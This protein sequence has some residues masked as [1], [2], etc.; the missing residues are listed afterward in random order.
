ML[1]KKIGRFIS[2]VY[3]EID[4]LK[5]DSFMNTIEMNRKSFQKFLIII[6]LFLSGVITNF[7]AQEFS[8]TVDKTTIGQSDRFQAV[9]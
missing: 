3:Q 4:N 7:Y 9:C 5:K 2:T 6:L 8:A 1:L